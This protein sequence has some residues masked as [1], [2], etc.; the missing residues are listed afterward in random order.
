MFVVEGRFVFI[1]QLGFKQADK[2]IHVVS[3]EAGLSMV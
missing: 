3:K 2:V 1:S